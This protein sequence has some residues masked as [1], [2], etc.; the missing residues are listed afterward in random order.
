MQSKRLYGL[1]WNADFALKFFESLGK[2]EAARIWA[3]KVLCLP[4]DFL[5]DWIKQGTQVKEV[6]VD[7]QN[8]KVLLPEVYTKKSLDI[9]LEFRKIAKRYE[10]SI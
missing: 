4:F 2:D 1:L 5:G 10:T 9:S 7:T 6:S 8:G 3:L